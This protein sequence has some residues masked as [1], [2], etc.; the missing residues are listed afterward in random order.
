MKDVRISRLPT[1]DGGELALHTYGPQEPDPERSVAIVCGAFLPAA[2]YAPFAVVLRRKLGQDWAVH[3]HDRRGKGHSSEIPDDYGLHTEIADVATV[4]KETGARHLLG[5]SLGGAV[6]L[7][8]VRHFQGASP[9]VVP[10]STMVYDPAVNLDGSLDTSWLD[11][12]EQ[13]VDAGHYGRAMDLA[14]RWFGATPTLSKAPTW[15]S[16]GALA[17]SLRTPLRKIGKAVF[18]AAV[19]E[20]SAALRR[21]ATA[22]DFAGLPRNFLFVVGE[23]SAEYFH[24]T[25]EALAKAVPG[26]QLRVAPHGFH[27]SIPAVRHDAVGVVADWLTGED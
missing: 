21:S 1:S 18:P 13:A 3:V 6:T 22:E 23:R 19:A 14:D 2:V 26:S 16:A 10:E 4:L 17:L 12:F 9:E 8:A 27:G 25:T 15:M 7:H 24:A 20:L 11:D 5:H